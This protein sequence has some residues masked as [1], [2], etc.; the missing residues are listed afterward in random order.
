MLEYIVNYTKMEERGGTT[1]LFDERRYEM[2]C[3]RL[4]S[5]ETVYRN[6][7][8]LLLQNEYPVSPEWVHAIAEKGADGLRDAIIR[9]T[10]NEAKRLKVPFRIAEQWKRTAIQEVPQEMWRGCD[11]LR[12]N[13]VSL[14]DNLPPLSFGYKD[15]EGVIM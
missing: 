4:D 1:F 12:S 9:D 8:D 6:I 15:T 5:I 11:A 14:S 10:E 3:S 13:V 2:L 7:Y